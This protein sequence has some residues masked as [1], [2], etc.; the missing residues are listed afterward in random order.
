MLR[1]EVL[2]G[3]PSRSVRTSILNQKQ[4]NWTMASTHTA[5]DVATA[6]FGM[7][8]RR[9]C[10]TSTSSPGCQTIAGGSGSVLHVFFFLGKCGMWS[11]RAFWLG[12]LAI[13][14]N[15][16]LLDNLDGISWCFLWASFQHDVAWNWTNLMQF[17]SPSLRSCECM[18]I[19]RHNGLKSQSQGS[20]FYT[21]HDWKILYQQLLLQAAS[22][23]I[24]WW[25]YPKNGIQW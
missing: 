5:V 23:D 10:G 4:P 14:M 1:N 13:V 16:L 18:K 22:T 11:W 7:S 12:E 15:L 20:S 17:Q 9:P 2:W 25:W 21:W 6:R 24:W 3:L 8:I 19:Q